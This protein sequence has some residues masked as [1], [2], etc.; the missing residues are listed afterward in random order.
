[1]RKEERLTK[2]QQYELVYRRGVSQV[3]DLLVMRILPNG[4][5]FSRYGFSVSKRVGGAVVR[6]RLKR[7]LREILPALPVIPG[8]DVVFVVRPPAA[9]ADFATLK[10]TVAGLLSRG[11]LLK[12]ETEDGAVSGKISQEAAAGSG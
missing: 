7:R 2:P 8:W 12:K 3:S 10:A 6:N 4:L 1:M 11:G 5:D 9:T